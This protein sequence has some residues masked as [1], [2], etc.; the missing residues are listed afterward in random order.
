MLDL[1]GTLGLLATEVIMGKI[2]NVVSGLLV[3]RVFVLPEAGTL[4]PSVVKRSLQP[5]ISVIRGTGLN[6]ITRI[7]RAIILLGLLELFW[8]LSRRIEELF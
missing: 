6:K 5:F 8:K 4:A 1:H 7:F 2:L 3:I